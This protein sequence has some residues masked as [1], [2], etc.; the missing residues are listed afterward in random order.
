MDMHELLSQIPFLE[1]HNKKNRVIRIIIFLIL[2]SL[3]LLFTLWLISIS[4]KMKEF[5]RYG[6]LGVLVANL[7]AS[8]TILIPAPAWAATIA[9]GAVLNPA[10]VAIAASVGTAIGEC[11]S[12]VLGYFGRSAILKNKSAIYLKAERWVKKYGI[13]TVP[14]LSFFPLL[15]F[16]LVGIASGA[17]GL[18]FWKFIIAVWVGRVPRAFIESYFGAGLAH[19]LRNIFFQ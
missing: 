10:L 16:D 3:Y 12:Y 7:L 14:V 15:P 4:F 5:A 13:Y 11:S 2:I 6:Y 18:P 1:I 19:I 8:A 17:L 9:A